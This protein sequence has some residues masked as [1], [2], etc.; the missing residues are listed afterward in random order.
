MP[1]TVRADAAT[2]PAPRSQEVN[3]A[4]NLLSEI[5]RYHRNALTVLEDMLDDYFEV[6]YDPAL[7]PMWLDYSFD[8]NAARADVVFDNLV[9]LRGL[10]ENMEELERDLK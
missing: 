5:R 2:S 8:K 1:N 3:K 6:Q 9:K 7:R 4:I 10:L